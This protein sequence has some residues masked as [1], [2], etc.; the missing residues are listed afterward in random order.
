MLRA[1]LLSARAAANFRLPHILS[2]IHSS[3]CYARKSY[4]RAQL[5]PPESS[6]VGEKIRGTIHK[7]YI[8]IAVYVPKRVEGDRAPGSGHLRG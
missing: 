8:Y 5:H 2:F 3:S 4:K 6:R 7:Q 1:L